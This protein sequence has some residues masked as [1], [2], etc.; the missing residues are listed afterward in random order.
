[1]AVRIRLNRIGSKKKP[2]YRIVVIDS[3]RPRNGRFIE[4]IGHYD[5]RKKKDL[6]LDLQKVEEWIQK[7]AQPSNTVGCLI[8]RLKEEKEEK[9]KETKQKIKKEKIE[10]V[11]AKKSKE[12]KKEPEKPKKEEKEEKTEKEE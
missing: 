10:K 4:T 11:E 9:P 6:I 8:K 5:P 3:R 12:S 2:Y 7:G 1:V